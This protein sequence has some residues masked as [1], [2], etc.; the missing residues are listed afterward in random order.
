MR[1]LAIK[2]PKTSYT[3]GEEIRGSLELVCDKP[4]DSKGTT[5]SV[6]GVLEAKGEAYPKAPKGKIAV[7]TKTAV[8]ALLADSNMLSAPRR[9][10]AGT[11][12]FDFS[13]QLPSSTYNMKSNLDIS[14]GLLPSYEG[15]HASIKYSIQA[16]IEVSRFR[17]VKTTTPLFIFIP[18]E[19][20]SKGM[21]LHV[22]EKGEKLVEFET[23]TRVSCI[24]SPFELR[25]RFNSYRLISKVRFELLHKESTKVEYAKNSHSRSLWKADVRPRK[26]D[27]NKWQTLNI[28]PRSRTPQSFQ[29][30]QITSETLLK[31]TAELT[32]LTSKENTVRLIAGHCPVRKAQTETPR[33]SCP[34]CKEELTNI[35][36]IVRPDG[37]VICPKCF[38]RFTPQHL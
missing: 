17:N 23:D 2:V 26:Q 37:S 12:T 6:Q 36:G 24:G 25:Y 35:S 15:K 28:E 16:E 31:V 11:H 18:V 33:H 8:Q 21:Q 9:Y 32:D 14:S 30:K 19:R 22:V 1:K 34:N 29:T 38:T 20:T 4:F 27:I 10:E 13:F 7:E 5:I 3:P